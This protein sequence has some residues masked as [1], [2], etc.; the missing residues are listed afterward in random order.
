MQDFDFF[1]LDIFAQGTPHA[2]F[3]RF[4]CDQPVAW[5]PIPHSR[6]GQGFWLVTRHQDICEVARQPK[7]FL[8]HGGSVLTD[9]V[10]IPHPAW[11]MIREG[12]CHLDA[13]QHGPLRRLAMPLFGA[14]AMTA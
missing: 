4:R 10:T 3:A 12:L 9:A 1:N 13:P 2:A 6:D 7:L 5:L 14:E 8:S 11:Q